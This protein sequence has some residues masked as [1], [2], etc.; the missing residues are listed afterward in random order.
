MFRTM[1]R[2]LFGCITARNE[3]TPLRTG[4]FI[5][6][7]DKKRLEKTLDSWFHV[8]NQAFIGRFVVGRAPDFDVDLYMEVVAIVEKSIH[9]LRGC[10]ESANDVTKQ[11]G[12]VF[13]I[14]LPQ[15]KSTVFDRT[16][17]VVENNKDALQYIRHLGPEVIS[18]NLIET[19]VT[20][21]A[22]IYEHAVRKYIAFTYHPSDKMYTFDEAKAWFMD[23][24][25][26]IFD[27]HS[28]EL[29]VK[30]AIAHKLIR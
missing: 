7:T 17:N 8:N 1:L 13:N 21:D 12:G 9:M 15:V 14:L 4:N 26:R 25:E 6:H 18:K 24:M 11:G 27:M 29:C 10:K 28:I 23:E 22:V 19:E 2:G 30:E 3:Y 16:A 20:W 5:D